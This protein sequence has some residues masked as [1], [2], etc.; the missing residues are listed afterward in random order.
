[1]S[2]GRGQVGS[3]KLSVKSDR[4]RR[5]ILQMKKKNECA[6]V[7]KRYKMEER[8]EPGDVGLGDAILPSPSVLAGALNF[9]QV[10]TVSCIHHT[11]H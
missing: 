7:S 6:V 4:E 10:W 2:C 3:R 5:S 8:R 1:M 9:S 11:S